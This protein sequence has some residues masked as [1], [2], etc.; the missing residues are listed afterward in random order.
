MYSKAPIIQGQLSMDWII[1][2][3][4]LSLICNYIFLNFSQHCLILNAT[5]LINFKNECLVFFLYMFCNVNTYVCFYVQI[6]LSS[7][8]AYMNDDNSNKI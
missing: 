5:R 7:Y 4:R 6:C 8:F 1:R 2:G 3:L